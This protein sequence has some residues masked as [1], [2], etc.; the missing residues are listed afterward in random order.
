MQSAFDS[1]A[2]TEKKSENYIILKMTK[3]YL[4]AKNLKQYSNALNQ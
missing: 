4:E 3:L 1:Y 2:K